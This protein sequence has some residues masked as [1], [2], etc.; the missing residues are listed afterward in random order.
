MIALQ[1][2]QTMRKRKQVL[3]CLKET[4]T[5]S[6]IGNEPLN[7]EMYLM[8][9]KPSKMYFCRSHNTP[10]SNLTNL[11]KPNE[12][13]K[14]QKIQVLQIDI[15]LMKS[16]QVKAFQ[17]PMLNKSQLKQRNKQSYSN[18]SRI[19]VNVFAET[20]QSLP[21]QPKFLEFK[22]EIWESRECQIAIIKLFRSREIIPI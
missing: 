2:V 12:E 6:I 9:S 5:R 20:Q 8:T 22:N 10:R 19:C 4:I 11:L 7:G 1:Q 16:S 17:I 3:R 14:A 15:W 18:I 21:Y 13:K